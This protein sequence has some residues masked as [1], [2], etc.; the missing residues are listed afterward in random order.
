ME[1]L[2]GAVGITRRFS[3]DVKKIATN[4]GDLD[5]RY[6]WLMKLVKLLR[7]LLMTAKSSPVAG[8]VDD[9]ILMNQMFYT[10]HT[11]Q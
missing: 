8:I 10:H 5:R 11:L 9:F 3:K 2:G 7:Y 1:G 6:L 4:S